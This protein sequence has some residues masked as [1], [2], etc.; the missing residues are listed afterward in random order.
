MAF[1][2][3]AIVKFSLRIKPGR[4]LMFTSLALIILILDPKKSNQDPGLGF[5]AFILAI[6]L[7]ASSFQFIFDSFYL[8]FLHKLLHFHFEE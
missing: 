7:S 5:N 4:P 1:L 3:Q 8:F 6:I 2:E